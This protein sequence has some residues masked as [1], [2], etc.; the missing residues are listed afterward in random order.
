MNLMMHVAHCA[1]DLDQDSIIIQNESVNCEMITCEPLLRVSAFYL[2]LALH[3]IL[4]RL[5]I[6]AT[7]IPSPTSSLQ[8]QHRAQLPLLYHFVFHLKTLHIAIL[9][10]PRHFWVYWI[11]RISPSSRA[12]SITR[13][14]AFM[15]PAVMLTNTSRSITRTILIQRH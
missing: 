3:L 15:V 14:D 10:D 12:V 2:G 4:Y 13:L 6:C 8:E 9:L 11:F 5:T 1:N 7:S